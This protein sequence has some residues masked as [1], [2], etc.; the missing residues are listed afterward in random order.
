MSDLGLEER[1][2]GVDTT[3]ACQVLYV[4]LGLWCLSLGVIVGRVANT[5]LPSSVPVEAT[6]IELSLTISHIKLLLTLI[7]K[8]PYR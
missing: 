2:P 5:S 1:A 3:H 6:R 4:T 7:T 8:K